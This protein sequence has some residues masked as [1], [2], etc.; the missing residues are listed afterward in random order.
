MFSCVILNMQKEKHGVEPNEMILSI[1]MK[2]GFK[3]KCD[4]HEPIEA[5]VYFC[6]HV[7]MYI[8]LY[9]CIYSYYTLFLCLW[10]EEGVTKFERQV[11]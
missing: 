5:L 7:V 2:H 8:L 4:V 3:T 6:I 11:D 1:G 10:L 9:K